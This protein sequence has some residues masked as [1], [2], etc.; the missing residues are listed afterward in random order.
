MEIDYVAVGKRIRKRRR[1]LRMSQERLSELIDV[2]IPHMS[3]IENGKTKFSLQ[4]LLDLSNALDTTPDMLLLDHLKNK[5]TARGMVMA[6]MSK[7]LEGCT[8]VQMTMMEETLR[9]TK[10]IL[11][12]YEK[13]IKSEEVY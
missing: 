13:K 3:N 8:P 4:V 12:Q 9:V 11:Q 6:E 7:V 2:S 10:K 1:E 5:S